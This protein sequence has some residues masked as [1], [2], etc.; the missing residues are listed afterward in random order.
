MS[1]TTV[2]EGVNLEKNEDNFHIDNTTLEIST[3]Q[4][5]DLPNWRGYLR[6]YDSF[7]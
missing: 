2:K 4:K 5:Y 7:Y 1:L 3:K 6:G